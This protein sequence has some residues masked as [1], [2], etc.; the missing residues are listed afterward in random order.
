[1]EA[2]KRYAATASGLGI[3][4]SSR[5]VVLARARDGFH[6]RMAR[7]ATPVMCAV[8]S[9]RFA[10]GRSGWHQGLEKLQAS[11]PATA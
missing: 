4:V 5:I 11:S 7:P 9:G 3:T 10:A 2:D 1:M 8:S 6:V